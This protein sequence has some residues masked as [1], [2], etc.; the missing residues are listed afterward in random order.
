MNEIKVY[1][2]FDVMDILQNKQIKIDSFSCKHHCNVMYWECIQG[3][4]TITKYT[5]E[6]LRLSKC[7]EIVETEGQKVVRYINGLKGSLQNKIGLHDV[8][9]IT[10]A[11][12]LIIKFF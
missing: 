1:C 2:Y 8:W 11:F 4:K 3:M 10:K 5:T 7:I 6:F 12:S 9:T